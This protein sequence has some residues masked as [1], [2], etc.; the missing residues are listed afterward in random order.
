[1]KYN[2]PWSKKFFHL[3]ILTMKLPLRKALICIL[4]VLVSFLVYSRKVN[5][6]EDAL[7]ESKFENPSD[8]EFKVEPCFFEDSLTYKYY[9][10]RKGEGDVQKNIGYINNKFG[11]YVYSTENFI[12]KA[13]E[14]I[15]SNGGDWG[16]VLIP[17]NVR[18]YDGSKWRK[19]FDLLNK[20]HLIPIIQLWDF[21]AKSYKK[22]TEKAANFLNKLLW[23]I[24]KKYISV[25]NETNDS[26]FWKGK[27]DPKE[28]AEVLDFTIKTFKS[29][30][31]G[32]FMLNGAFNSTAPNLNGYMDEELYLVRMNDST[33]G[34]FSKL[35]G[36]AS[37]PYPMPAYLGKPS[38]YGRQSV[39]GYEWELDVL[40]NRFG[41]ETI[42]VFITETGWPHAEGKNHNYGFYDSNTVAS[43]IKETFEKVWLKDDRVVAIT[44]FTIYYDPPFDHFSWVK[45]DGSVYPQF[46][47]IKSLKKVSGRPPVLTY[48]EKEVITCP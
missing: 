27:V 48:V 10:D 1:M 20:K 34:I 11:L 17:Y 25:Y 32:F 38:E 5:L 2:Y 9:E 37:H 15:N 43:Y 6:N 16:Y 3:G 41:I 33:P 35:D 8:I 23:P 24:E 18:D 21:S 39:R 14:L 7:F 30:D 45:K 22:D 13:D 28:Y 40:K 12:K 36:W 47:L 4:I 26:R 44:P 46:D 19:I 42:P 31:K 29:Y